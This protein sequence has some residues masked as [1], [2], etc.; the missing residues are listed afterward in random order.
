MHQ[1]NLFR[2]CLILRELFFLIVLDNH[3]THSALD[4]HDF[5]QKFSIHL[6]IFS[7]LTPHRTLPPVSLFKP[8]KNGYQRE[9]DNYMIIELSGN[10]YNRVTVIE[11]ILNVIKQR[12]YSSPIMICSMRTF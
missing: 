8:S 10:A 4:S 9:C 3:S 12:V 6:I 11:N 1:G 5:S 7:P 2:T